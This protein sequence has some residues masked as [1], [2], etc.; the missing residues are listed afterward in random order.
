[1]FFASSQS[2]LQEIPKKWTPFGTAQTTG[3]LRIFRRGGRSIQGRVL[4][5]K[6]FFAAASRSRRSGK[7]LPAPQQKF[8]G[9]ALKR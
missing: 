4:A 9:M 7:H 2:S 3:R 8:Y 1:M 6:G 5:V